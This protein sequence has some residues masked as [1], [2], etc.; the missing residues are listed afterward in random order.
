MTTTVKKN[1]SQ[2]SSLSRIENPARIEKITR[3]MQTST[4]SSCLKSKV[5][6]LFLQHQNGLACAK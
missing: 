2:D 1:M 5:T 3:Y 4:S 6:F